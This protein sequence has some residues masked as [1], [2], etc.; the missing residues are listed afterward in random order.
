MLKPDFIVGKTT[1]A[2]I[3]LLVVVALA[4]ISHVHAAGGGV[5]CPTQSG[6]H[7]GEEVTLSSSSYAGVGGSDASGVGVYT[8][9]TQ[10]FS[11]STTCISISIEVELEGYPADTS[12]TL[13]VYLSTA[14]GPAALSDLLST[15]VTF[16]G[17][18]QLVT[19]FTDLSLFA[20]TYYLTLFSASS[21]FQWFSDSSVNATFTIDDSVTH[22]NGSDV[23]STPSINTMTPWTAITSVSDTDVFQMT[24]YLK[25]AVYHASCDGC[26]TDSSGS[27]VSCTGT[28]LSHSSRSFRSLSYFRSLPLQ[29]HCVQ[30][31]IMH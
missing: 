27:C 4:I 18:R 17:T 11:L 30:H 2:S 31:H 23:V 7:L 12:T 16:N 21:Q 15:S 25:H 26:A 5:F 20:G 10:G 28:K 14:V 1:T 19:A 13:Q 6:T 24:I 22:I 8:V 29:R 9:A 3:L